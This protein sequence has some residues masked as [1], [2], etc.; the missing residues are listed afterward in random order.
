MREKTTEQ[1]LILSRAMTPA[2]RQ[3]LETTPKPMRV[4][5]R[6]LPADLNDLTLGELFRLQSAG[7]DRELIETVAEVLL[8]VTPRRALRENGMR[9][10]GF[11]FW[12]GRELERIAGMFAA[13]NTPPTGDEIRAGI[14]ELD[15]GPFGIIDWYA[16]RQGYADQNEA[17]NAA[18]IRVYECMRIDNKRA[19]YERRLRE[20]MVEKYHR[21]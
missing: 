5:G 2:A 19:A 6:R 10:Y 21:K 13:I 3:M 20:I 15:F 4:C 14:R 16:R 18:W 7:G 9:M 8:K 17:A 12:V 11:V 1:L